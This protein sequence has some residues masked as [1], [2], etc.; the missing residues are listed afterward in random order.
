MSKEYGLNS[1]F[2]YSSYLADRLRDAHNDPELLKALQSLS[3]ITYGG[4]PLEHG[5]A[6]W[7]RSQGI[8]M[9]EVFASTEVGLIMMTVGGD[10][11]D[12]T[13][14]RPMTGASYK[15]LPVET[16]EADEAGNAMGGRLVEL[17]VPAGARDCPAP[18]LRNKET[19][20]FHTGDMFVEVKPGCYESKGRNDDWIKTSSA[21][22]CDTLAIENNIMEKCAHDIVDRVVV[23]GSGRPS[24]AVLVELKAGQGDPSALSKEILRRITPFHERRYMHERIDH[25]RYVVI[26]PQGSLPKTAKGSL[27]RRVVERSFQTTLDQVYSSA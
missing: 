7:A 25:A 13:L 12:S 20:D 21:L 14:L 6:A 22:R 26:V 16:A 17:V 23:V 11:P 2:M 10:G 18:A 9:T 5:E 8:N 1:L 3:Q 15:F 4:L 24:P 27:Q 19:G